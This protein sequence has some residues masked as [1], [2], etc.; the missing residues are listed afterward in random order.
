MKKQGILVLVMITALFIGFICG[1]YIGRS[2]AGGDILISKTPETT[3]PTQAPPSP[4]SPPET[5]LPGDTAA[6]EPIQTAPQPIGKINLNTATKEQ[7]TQLPGI[8][9]VLAERIIRY[10]T[11]QGPFKK[12]HDL[13]KVE[14]IGEKKLDAIIDYLT[15]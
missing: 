4:T 7:L 13:L 12:V 11:A 14:G 8:G 15:V 3:V 5:A 6:T 2:D 9:E 1:L 10:R